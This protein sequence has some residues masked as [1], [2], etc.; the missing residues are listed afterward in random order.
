MC[1]QCEAAQSPQR[2]RQHWYR[3]QWMQSVPELLPGAAER[4]RGCFEQRSTDQQGC[5]LSS[6]SDADGTQLRR[7]QQQAAVQALMTLADLGLLWAHPAGTC[8]LLAR[9]WRHIGVKQ[10]GRPVCAAN[11]A[12]LTT[13]AG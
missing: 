10:K 5:Y 12:S 9:G 2:R 1:V 13:R 7:Q 11:T 4:S 6:T 8:S 3:D